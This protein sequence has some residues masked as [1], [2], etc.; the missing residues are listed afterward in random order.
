[1]ETDDSFKSCQMVR[2]FPPFRSGWEK[3]STS[4][5]TPQFP[6][7]I[8]GR[9]PYHLTSNRT[10]R[11]FWPNGK[12]AMPPSRFHL[13]DGSYTDTFAMCGV[14]VTGS[15]CSLQGFSELIPHN[16]IQ[17]FDERELEVKKRFICYGILLKG[18]R[19]PQV[20]AGEMVVGAIFCNT[21]IRVLGKSNFIALHLRI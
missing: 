17:I 20:F 1:M 12:H 2:N 8:S 18:H 21:E 10:F 9:L 14:I 16:L 19:E 5:G 11:I 6:N 13:L 4:E 3:R 15:F 7:G